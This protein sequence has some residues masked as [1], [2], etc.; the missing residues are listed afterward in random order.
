MSLTVSLSSDLDRLSDKCILP[1]SILTAALESHPSLP[2]PLVFRLHASEHSILVGVK[3]FTAPEGEILVPQ[4]VFD[5]L[6]DVTVHVELADVP[7]ATFLQLKPRHFYPHITNWKY[8]LESFVS[9]S[10]TV[11][12]KK[13]KFGVYDAVAKMDV[14]LQ[15]EDANEVLV[16]VVDTDIELDV[17]PL[18]D[19]MAAQQ[20]AHNQ[21]LSYL[22]NIPEVVWDAPIKLEPFN[23]VQ[24]PAIHRLD[25]RKLT[26]KSYIH[27][28][29]QEDIYNVDLLAGLD[30]FVTLE[31]FSWCTMAQDPMGRKYIEID[32]NSDSVANYMLKHT[33]DTNCWVYVVPFAWEHAS[34]VQLSIST[35]APVHQAEQIQASNSSDIQCTN[36]L[37]YIDSS[38]FSLHE[39]FCRRHNVRCSCSEVF[40]QSIP[41][42][43]WHCDLCESG[44]HGNSSLFKI[45]H[46]KLFHGGPYVCE[47]CEDDGSYDNFISLVQNHKASECG[48]KLHECI[49]CH[50]VVPQGVASYEEKFNNLTHHESQCGNKTVECFECGKVVKSKDMASHMKIHYLNKMQSAAEEVGRCTNV[51]CVNIFGQGPLN[52]ANTVASNELGLCDGCFGS[53]YAQVHDPTHIK[54]QNRLERK[55]VMQLTKGCG[56]TWCENVECGNHRKWDIR[57]ALDHIKELLGDIVVPQLPINEKQKSQHNDNG[58]NN[59]K[60]S[61]I[62]TK[63]YESSNQNMT[64][65]HNRMWFC[66]NASVAARRVLYD[67]I[68]SEGI[69]TLNMILKALAGNSD[70]TNVR[71]WLQTHSV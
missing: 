29:T 45:K 9:K 68:M 59:S 66:L 62:N 56:N 8:Y 34:T 40:P 27:L 67:K 14:E 25:L 50:V 55:Y 12:T 11:L 15:V 58:D 49:F 7:K 48:A 3:E 41:S 70:E 47:Q 44:I 10:Y 21:N 37:K 19:I 5:R 53:L 39:A 65:K 61:D 1:Q 13:Q 54:L 69:Y 35:D 24:I 64:P 22:E 31:N 32:K 23:Q 20:L 18:N 52:G 17:V 6:G 63:H 30:R 2:H 71:G 43:H 42:T 28:T 46:D 51:N 36:C 16:V 60:Q 33:D 26:A 4:A 38:K 57:L